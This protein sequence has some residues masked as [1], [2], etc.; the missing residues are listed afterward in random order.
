MRINLDDIKRYIGSRVRNCIRAEVKSSLITLSTR[1]LI[2]SRASKRLFRAAEIDTR[3][4]TR[5][6][7]GKARA[8]FSGP[9]SAAL[10]FESRRI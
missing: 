1:R 3:A 9:L 7:Q 4:H 8:R 10:K 6:G 5:D 2:V